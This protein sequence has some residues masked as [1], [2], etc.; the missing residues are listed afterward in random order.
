MRVLSV[1]ALFAAAVVLPLAAAS[2]Q[3][4]DDIVA[5]N[6]K[7]KGGLD[8]I[9]ATQTV[10]MTGSVMK[11]SGLRTVKAPGRYVGPYAAVHAFSLVDAS[12]RPLQGA[13]SDV[14]DALSVP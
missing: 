12:G 6:L 10:R 1:A 9:R 4:L 7:S 3:T 2:A 13:L 11:S 5:M 14:H 8:K